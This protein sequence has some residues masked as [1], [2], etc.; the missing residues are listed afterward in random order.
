MYWKNKAYEYLEV[1]LKLME[2][3]RRVTKENE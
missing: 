1:N 3:I 2:D